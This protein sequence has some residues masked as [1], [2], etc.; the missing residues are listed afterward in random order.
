M[1][2]TYSFPFA[3]ARNGASRRKFLKISGAGLGGLALAQVLG[4]APRPARA[5]GQLTYAFWPWGSEIVTD[6]ARIFK[7]Q[8]GEE[9]NLQ[10]IPGEYAA[11]IETKLAAGQ[12]FD[13]FRA[14]RGQ[15]S[16]WYAA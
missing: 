2:K 15:A 10:P 3:I 4:L 6:N 8:Y 14:Q 16:R 1:P 12:A 13:L 11:V 5:A 7:E 9:I